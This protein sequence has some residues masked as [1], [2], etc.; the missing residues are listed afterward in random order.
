MS[1]QESHGIRIPRFFFSMDTCNQRFRCTES[2]NN[3]ILFWDKDGTMWPLYQPS[4]CGRWTKLA[5]FQ[6][7]GHSW[8]LALAACRCCRSVTKLHLT[9][10]NPMDCSFYQLLC[11]LLSSVWS[12]PCP[13][14]QR[15]PSS[16]LI[17]C[18]PLLL[19][20]QSFLASGFF[21]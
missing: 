10:C 17:L 15:W 8:T 12:Y 11:P 4:S 21:Q 14:S 1:T 13:L 3:E 2:Y 9:L 7:P 19:C 6:F 18:L 5:P 20:P 16:H